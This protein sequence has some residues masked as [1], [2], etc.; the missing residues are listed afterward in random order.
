MSTGFQYL[1]YLSIKESKLHALKK[2]TTIKLPDN[3]PY[4]DYAR[5]KYDTIFFWYIYDSK[6]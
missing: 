1:K 3:R 4:D 5:V 2:H 6:K